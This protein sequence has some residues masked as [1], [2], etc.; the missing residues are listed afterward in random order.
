MQF[1]L[2]VRYV[3][4]SGSILDS[5]L[6]L[7][8]LWR[9]NSRFG[10]KSQ[11]VSSG[12]RLTPGT[13]RRSWPD[14]QFKQVSQMNRRLLTILVVAF[15][16]A[17][18]C[19]YLVAHMLGS[20]LQQA[21]PPATQSVVAANAD[22]KLGTILK[23][24]D[25]TTIQIAGDLPT[26]AIVK[27]EQAVGRGVISE[28]YKGE[29]IL[30]TRLAAVGAGGGLAAAIPL[31][32]RACAVR[33]DDVVAVSGFVTP[34]SRVDVLISGTPP[35]PQT[36]NE[37]TQAR[38]LLQDIQV[39][40]AGTDIQSD[41]EGKARQVGVVNVLLTPEQAESL[42]LAQNQGV[43]FQLVL[44]NPLDTKTDPVPGTAM[45]NIFADKTVKPKA[46]A[47]VRAPKKPASEAYSIEIFSGTSHSTTKFASPEEKP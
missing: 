8:G 11:L 41:K 43:R 14:S 34:G 13:E 15:I 28:L 22:I 4:L 23:P 46:V 39:L 32:F 33:V 1:A 42:T 6:N 38:T 7:F 12:P 25:L 40:S 10:V 37:G 19:T 20:R 21:K 45:V 17:A 9:V 47:V 5:R 18:G 24:A 44:R 16:I 29:P 30:D 31:G 3:A 26:G 27:P 36:G 35:G 2:F